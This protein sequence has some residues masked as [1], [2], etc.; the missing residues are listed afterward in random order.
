MCQF[1]CPRP[2]FI[3]N[4]DS[5]NRP[6]PERAAGAGRKMTLSGPITK[7]RHQGPIKVMALQGGG[8]LGMAAVRSGAP[9]QLSPVSRIILAEPGRIGRYHSSPYGTTRSSERS[10]MDT[11][12]YS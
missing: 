8:H 3:V 12:I 6:E 1:L 7:L 9:Q 11:L 10:H 5:M 2:I 4:I